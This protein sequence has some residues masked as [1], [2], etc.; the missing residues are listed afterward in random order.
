MNIS[1]ICSNKTC[2][3]YILISWKHCT[4]NVTNFPIFVSGLLSNKQSK[5][6]FQNNSSFKFSLRKLSNITWSS[7]W[8]NFVIIQ[9]QNFSCFILQLEIFNYVEHVVYLRVHKRSIGFLLFRSSSL[10]LK[11]TYKMFISIHANF[12]R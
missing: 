9:N 12:K 1:K 7:Q 8:D 11:F 3:L 2:G 6:L 10:R 4:M 5:F